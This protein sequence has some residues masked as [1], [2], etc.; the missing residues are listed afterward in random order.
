MAVLLESTSA[1][2]VDDGKIYLLS[3]SQGSTHVDDETDRLQ[4]DKNGLLNPENLA[5]FFCAYSTFI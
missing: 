1:L 3:R 4:P 5:I 2:Q